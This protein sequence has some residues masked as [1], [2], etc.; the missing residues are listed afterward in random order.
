MS[1]PGYPN[2][3]PV[4]AVMERLAEA[5][6]SNFHEFWPDDIS[7]LDSKVATGR[8]STDRARSPMSI[9]LRSRFATAGSSS[10]STPR[11]R[12]MPSSAQGKVMFSCFDP[13][14]VMLRG[15]HVMQFWVQHHTKVVESAYWTGPG[16]G[17]AFRPAS[18][19]PNHR[20][21]E[22]RIYSLY[23]LRIKSAVALPCPDALDPEAVADVELVE[24][25]NQELLESCTATRTDFE[26]DGFSATINYQDGTVRVCW[27]DHFEFVV[28]GDGTRVLWRRLVGIPDEVLFTYLLNQVL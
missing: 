17:Y 27:R 4:R 26:D 2:A 19:A 1:H 14:L 5:S 11:F 7:L 6:A 21:H 12:A 10:R 20:W 3:L 22:R 16:N 25:T 15:G 13:G 23:G 9:C 8:A 24:S 18:T 28:S